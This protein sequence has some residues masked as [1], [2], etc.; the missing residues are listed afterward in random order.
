MKQLLIIGHGSRRAS[1]NNEVREV[2]NKVKNSVKIPVDDVAVAFLEFESPSIH[3]ALNEGFSQGVEDVLVLPYFLAGGNHVVRDIPEEINK[4][5]SQW[6]DKTITIL[7]HIGASAGMA[8]LISRAC[9]P[10]H[11]NQ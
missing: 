8:E 1:S 3:E 9:E 6:P 2:A 11:V 4:L 7:P 5:L 10:L